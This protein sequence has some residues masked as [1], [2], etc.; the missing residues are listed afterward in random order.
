M[1]TGEYGPFSSLDVTVPV[2]D[3]SSNLSIREIDSS[4]VDCS[5]LSGNFGNCSM[6]R[7][8]LLVR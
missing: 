4:N 6:V 7:L 5:V 3:V 2:R 8:V 1:T